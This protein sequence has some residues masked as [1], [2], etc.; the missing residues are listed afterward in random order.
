MERAISSLTLPTRS[1][2][3]LGGI[4]AATI[5]ILVGCTGAVLAL[6]WMNNQSAPKTLESD[7]D[8][9]NGDRLAGDV[10]EDGALTSTAAPGWS[11]EG[12]MLTGVM[13]VNTEDLL[14]VNRAIELKSIRPLKIDTQLELLTTRLNYV[15][16]REDGL[17]VNGY[18]GD[19]CGL[20]PVK[21]FGPTF[22]VEGHKLEPRDKVAITFFVRSV[23]PGDWTFGGLDIQY[24][25]DGKTKRMTAEKSTVTIHPRDRIEDL[26]EN[27]CNPSL[28]SIWL[29]DEDTGEPT[30]CFPSREPDLEPCPQR[31]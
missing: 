20:W 26:P 12:W 30:K 29:G 7:G 19:F 3:R 2:R 21:G 8:S 9:E 14:R 15:G 6:A 1:K 4:A 10:T 23:S 27:A 22:P 11:V 18:P 28:P 17:G 24:L 31:T 25:L 16:R 13:V 5:F